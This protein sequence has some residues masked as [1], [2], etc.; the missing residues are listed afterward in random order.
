MISKQKYLTFSIILFCLLLL[1]KTATATELRFGTQDFAPF[2]YE[3]DGVVSGPTADIIRTVCSEM[4]ISCSLRL[5]PWR[6]AQKE[7]RKGKVHGM[8]VIGWN[9]ERAEWLH[10]S[11]PIIMTEYGFFVREGNPLQFKQAQ[12]VKG[13]KVGVYGPSNTSKS[14]EDIKSEIKDLIID[15]R[16]DDESGFRKLAISRVDAVYSNKYVGNLMITKLGLKNIRYA[17]LHKKLKYYIGFS[18]KYADKKIVEKFNMVFKEL[19]KKGVIQKILG[20][21]KMDA[22]ELK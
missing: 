13:Y 12:D 10:F 14:L 1:T 17:G 15:L 20:K 19:H 3:I 18:K 4:D 7:V 9:K 21:Y 22:V 16:H 11:H 2:N 5:Y 8:F 6:R